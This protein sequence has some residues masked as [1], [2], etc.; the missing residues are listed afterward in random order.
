MKKG[1]GKRIPM[2]GLLIMLT[3]S[4]GFATGQKETAGTQQVVTI[5]HMNPHTAGEG[6]FGDYFAAHVEKFNAEHPYIHV[7]NDS[8]PSADLRTKIT[9]EMASGNP[10]NTAW[11]PYSYAM[12]FIKDDLII[13]WAKI[14]DDP[15]HPEFKDRFNDTILYFSQ[16]AD[17]K[18]PMVPFEAH[19]DGLFYN[20]EIFDR[21][22]WTVPKTFDEFVDLAGKAKK[23]G[24]AATVTGGQDIRF[25]W[26]AAALLVRTG[27]VKNA[28]ALASGDAMD[29]W[30]NPAYGFPQAM[31]KFN[32]MV[33]AG[34]YPEG[35]LAVSANMAD[36]MF[37]RGEAATYYEGQW[38]PGVWEDM[39]GKEFIEKIRRAD[40]PVMTDMPMGDSEARIG[41]TIV[42]LVAAANQ[43]PEELEA[44]ITWIKSISSPE[45]WA[46]V[47]AGGRNLYP[48]NVEYD[49]SQVPVVM[50]Q[51]AE[52]L[53]N[54]KALFPSMDTIA[55]PAVDL[56]IKRSA[57]PGLITGQ[58]TVEQA[59][60]VVQKAASDYLSTQE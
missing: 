20:K 42:G 32:Q 19:M 55:P 54:A 52:A 1:V 38:R 12:E 17:G 15:A 39:G 10:P 31:E 23:A 60:A 24:I 49:K 43:S 28:T 46:P 2:I 35:V 56:A 59:V 37:V 34:I 50:Q 44:S 29:Q 47:L 9:V 8:L 41:G 26:L 4:V 16:T 3:F 30:D 5:R 53:I 58:Y 51:C 22:G 57:M 33:K 7:I 36:Q 21:Y 40:F 25:A 48:G 14:Y 11:L 27:G 6:G 13:D 18:V 45:F